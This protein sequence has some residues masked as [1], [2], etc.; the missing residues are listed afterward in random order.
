MGNDADLLMAEYRQ[1]SCYILF[2]LSVSVPKASTH[3]Y[4]VFLG[5]SITQRGRF[6]QH[7][8]EIAWV[9]WKALEHGNIM[10]M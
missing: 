9:Q 3:S 4:L 7:L 8:E 6:M 10:K 1:H 5:K 2:R